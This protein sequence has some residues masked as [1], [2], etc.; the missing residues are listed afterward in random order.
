M[1]ETST[2]AENAT[3]ADMSAAR[4]AL[5]TLLASAGGMR[6]LLSDNAQSKIYIGY[7][8]QLSGKD[9]DTVK[10]E[11]QDV[12][13]QGCDSVRNDLKAQETSLREDQD[14]LKNLDK[15]VEKLVRSRRN[16]DREVSFF[17]LLG[18]IAGGL[19]GYFGLAKAL[20]RRQGSPEKM[21]TLTAALSTVAG[22][23]VGAGAGLWSACK[24]FVG[25]SFKRSEKL[26]KDYEPVIGH[27]HTLEK[28]IAD[29][30]QSMAEACVAQ[31]ITDAIESSVTASASPRSAALAQILAEEKRSHMERVLSS[32]AKQSRSHAA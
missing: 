29:R 13:Q 24:I 6:L 20:H 12:V 9:A 3:P 25:H 30:L 19:L 5:R 28:T 23:I 22:I 7:L 31:Y 26:K 18:G 15:P 10:K 32:A 16:A 11:I 1:E 8:A 14:R 27:V 17:T 4:D 21:H 2:S